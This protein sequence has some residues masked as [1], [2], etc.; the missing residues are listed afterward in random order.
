MPKPKPKTTPSD[1]QVTRLPLADLTP[2]PKNP[3]HIT[4]AA[5]N[6]VAESLAAFGWQQPIVIDPKKVIVAGHTRCL[7][8]LQIGWT[9]APTVTIAAKHARAYRLAD[10]RSGE[11]STWNL[12]VLGG[13]LAAIPSG[14]LEALPALDFSALALPPV[15]GQTDPDAIPEAPKPRTKLGDV[16]T[17]GEHRLMCGD[18]TDASNVALVLD[19][20]KPD[21][22]LTDPPYNLTGLSGGGI[23]GTER[24]YR[25]GILDDIIDFDLSAHAD[26]LMGNAPMLIAFHSRD[27]VPDYAALAREHG[28]KYDLHIWHKTN[29]PPFTSGTWKSD[30]EYIALL[31]AQRPGWKVVE[32]QRHSKVFQSST[33]PN[34]K[35]KYH[36]TQ[37]PVELLKKYIEILEA[38]QIF[39][40]LVGGGSTLIACEIL[41]RRCYAMEIS[42]AY[43]DVTVARWEAFT[44]RTATR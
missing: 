13:E 24:M 17:L 35:D 36:P 1:L 29:S 22:C 2:Y 10:N 3:R 25:S 5:V 39:D 41:K 8:A 38:Q 31:W 44:G 26:C 33:I 19:E 6:A 37:K 16:W 20:A 43:C 11:F 42:P 18:C 32:Q 34:G 9:H 27:L 28:R 21:L 40:P 15:E 12:D 7:A 23:A 30:V 14:Q 4:P